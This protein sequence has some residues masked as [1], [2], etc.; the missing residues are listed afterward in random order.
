MLRH[1]FHKLGCFENMLKQC[2]VGRAFA[3]TPEVLG[4][5]PVIGKLYITY[6]L[7]IEK[8]KIKKKCVFVV[9]L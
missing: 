4:S 9:N 2:S 8:S 3:S 6:S 5:N 1:S 7:P